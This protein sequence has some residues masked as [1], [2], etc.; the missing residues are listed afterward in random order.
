MVMATTHTMTRTTQL[1]DRLRIVSTDITRTIRTHVHPV[2]TGAR[3]ISMTVSLL[4][5]VPGSGGDLDRASVANSAISMTSVALAPLGANASGISRAAAAYEIS[6]AVTRSEAERPVAVSEAER[7]VAVSEAERPVAV[8]EAEHPVAV[9]EAW[10][11]VAVPEAEHPVAVSE[12]EHPVA[13][14]EAAAVAAA[15]GD[16]ANKLLLP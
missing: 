1:M 5:S 15:V 7:P 3:T 11:P 8:P 16:A 13:V 9:S 12:A 4:A 14:P 2:D 10:R 6:G